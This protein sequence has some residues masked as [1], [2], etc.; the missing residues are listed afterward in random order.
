MSPYFSGWFVEIELKP[1]LEPGQRVITH[2]NSIW[3][4]HGEATGGR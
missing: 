4:A 2:F 1:I 3:Q